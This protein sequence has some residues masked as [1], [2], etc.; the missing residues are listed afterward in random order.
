MMQFLTWGWLRRV[1]FDKVPEQSWESREGLVRT[2]A[3][4]GNA[5]TFTYQEHLT[6]DR[7]GIA[8]AGIAA[9]SDE[10]LADRGLVLFDNSTCR[11]VLRR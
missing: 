7:F 1:F 5:G 8:Q 4:S 11:M 9:Q 10:P 2:E 6:R 3:L